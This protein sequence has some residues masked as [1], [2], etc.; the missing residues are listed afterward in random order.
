[1]ARMAVRLL[2]PLLLLPAALSCLTLLLTN[3]TQCTFQRG[4]SDS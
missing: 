2:C 4:D 1:M 3:L